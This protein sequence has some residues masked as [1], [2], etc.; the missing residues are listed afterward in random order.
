MAI[1]LMSSWI[2]AAFLLVHLVDFFG[3]DGAGAIDIMWAG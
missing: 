2:K 1:S 3:V